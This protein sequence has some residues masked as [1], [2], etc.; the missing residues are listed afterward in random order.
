MS[1]DHL[2]AIR[3]SPR[4]LEVLEASYRNAGDHATADVYRTLRREAEQEAHDDQAV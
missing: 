1:A 2:D 3:H 4:T